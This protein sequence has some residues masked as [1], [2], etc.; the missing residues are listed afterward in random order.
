MTEKMIKV[1]I[2]YQQYHWKK[3]GYSKTNMCFRAGRIQ[4]LKS[5]DIKD[6]S[7]DVVISNCVINLLPSKSEIFKQIWRVL[8]PGG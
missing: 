8:K 5:L 4:D 2:Q 6:N 7:I 3:Y 1:A